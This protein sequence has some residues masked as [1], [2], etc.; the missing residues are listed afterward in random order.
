MKLRTLVL[1]SWPVSGVALAAVA[2]FA[3]VFLKTGVQPP[4]RS[5][6]NQL[7]SRGVSA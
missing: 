5:R 7:R 1:L 4:T 6:M 3:L 2:W